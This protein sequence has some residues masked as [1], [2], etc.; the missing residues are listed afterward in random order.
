[1]M[2]S[3]IFHMQ[4]ILVGSQNANNVSFQ[5]HPMFEQIIHELRWRGS[6]SFFGTPYTSKYANIVLWCQILKFRFRATVLINLRHLHKKF[7]TWPYSTFLKKT[8]ICYKFPGIYP[9]SKFYSNIFMEIFC[10]YFANIS[11]IFCI[12]VSYGQ[13]EIKILIQKFPKEFKI[14]NFHFRKKSNTISGF[15]ECIAI[16]FTTHS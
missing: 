16:I 11:H 3:N 5:L 1:M 6:D 15:Y 8:L 7:H 12:T 4:L 10:N 13:F 9:G 14:S 2:D